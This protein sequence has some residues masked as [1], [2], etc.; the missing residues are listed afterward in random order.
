V[1]KIGAIAGKAR[2]RALR[3]MA[4]HGRISDPFPS[5]GNQPR[6]PP[7]CCG[8]SSQGPAWQKAMPGRP[9]RQQM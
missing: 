5:F 1:Q 8:A 2:D 6:A 7:D 4:W 3:V 9:Q